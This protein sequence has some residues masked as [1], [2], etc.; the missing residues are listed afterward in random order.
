MHA[1][2]A[3]TI[4]RRRNAFLG[5][6]LLATACTPV[7]A[8]RGN[9]VENE[10]LEQLKVGQ[11]TRVEVLNLLGT[12]TSRATFDQD[13]WYYI[14]QITEQTAF[15]EPDVIERRI[16]RLTFDN[17]GTLNSVDQI[18]MDQA[19]TVQMVD[20]ETPTRGKELGFLEQMMGN[21]GRFNPP[22]K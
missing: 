5:L 3:T 8:Q 11:M 20:R 7:T 6:L 21:L 12:P 4:S 10:R 1:I 22:A 16:I 14:G 17:A 9:L 2:P 19:Q 15:F 18:N 13:T